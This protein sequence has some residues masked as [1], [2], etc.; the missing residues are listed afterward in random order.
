LATSQADPACLAVLNE[1]IVLAIVL[2]TQSLN[3]FDTLDVPQLKNNTDFIDESIAALK[4]GYAGCSSL[5][6][7]TTEDPKIP[8]IQQL[9]SIKARLTSLDNDLTD[10]IASEPTECLIMIQ[11]KTRELL[12]TVNNELASSD[13]KTL[14]E[15]E[16]AV[17][18]A[19]T[20]DNLIQQQLNVCLIKIRMEAQLA[21]LEVLKTRITSP[22]DFDEICKDNGLASVDGQI[23]ITNQLLLNINNYSIVNLEEM[24]NLTDASIIEI[25]NAY[26]ECIAQTQPTDIPSDT[27]TTTEITTTTES[28][29]EPAITQIGVTLRNM[30]TNMTSEI[31]PCY[32]PIKDIVSELLL[33]NQNYLDDIQT[34]DPNVLENYKNLMNGILLQEIAGDM[35]KCAT[36]QPAD[37]RDVLVLQQTMLNELAQNITI[38][39]DGGPNDP[40]CYTTIQ[41]NFNLT[42]GSLEKLLNTSDPIP[43]DSTIVDGIQEEIEKAKYDYEFCLSGTTTTAGE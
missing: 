40:D 16:T 17:E 21:T 12:N 13:S 18:S 43:Y 19:N 6:T 14:A 42:Q 7:T 11:S 4:E 30:E 39:L 1:V 28:P 22:D 9:E 8:F 26:D 23:T 36:P 34:T 10:I 29:Y 37:M 3:E 20:S 31:D 25:S 24:A 5:Q 41:E 38:I 32:E 27:S 2:N 15:L 35:A 33:T